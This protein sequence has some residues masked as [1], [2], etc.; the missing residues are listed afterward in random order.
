[1]KEGKRPP[2]IS[3]ALLATLLLAL[4]VRALGFEWVFIDADTVVFPPSDAQYHVRRSLYAWVNFPRVL[5][6]DP[7]INYPDGAAISWPPLFDF[8]VG[9]AAKLLARDTYS[10]QVVAAW[11]PPILGSIL[12]FPVYLLGRELGSRG[13]GVGAAAL[14]AM[15]PMS[16][17]YSRIGQLDHHCAV[18]FVG[19][20]LL[21]IVVRLVAETGSMLRLGIAF[22]LAGSAMLL[23]WH[24]S[25]LYLGMAEAILCVGAAL[26]GR[27][28]LYAVQAGSA[29][30]ILFVIGPVVWLFPEPLAGPYSAI[31]LSRLHVLAVMTV[32]LVSGS[33]WWGVRPGQGLR[34]RSPTARLAWTAFLLAAIAA[35]LLLLPGP[36]EGLEPAF[37][38]LTMTD[39]VG[40]RTGEQLP[41]F[42]LFGR[43]PGRPAWEIWGLFAYVIALAPVALVLSAPRDRRPAAWVLAAWCTVFGGLALVQ[44]RYGNDLGP[45]VAVAFAV[46]LAELSR[47]AASKFQSRACLAPVL[48]CG[49][50]LVMLAPPVWGQYR[51]LALN[52]VKALR[53]GN[54]GYDRASVTVAGTLTRFMQLVRRASP[55]TSGYFNVRDLPE[56]GIVAHANLGHSL[57]NIARRPTPT[58]P[59]WAFIGRENWNRSF[60]LLEAD[61]EARA[62]ELALQLRARYVVTMSSSDPRTLEGWLHHRDGLAARGWAASQHFRLIAEA[63]AGGVPLVGLFQRKGRRRSALARNTIPY[64]LFEIVNAAVLEVSAE[65]GAEVQL[66]LSLESPTGRSLRYQARA[67]AGPEGLARLRV[68]Y[69]TDGAADEPADGIRVFASDLYQVRVADCTVA[70]PVTDG[71]VRTGAVIVVPANADACRNSPPDA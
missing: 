49:I 54:D 57:Q 68:P 70:V 67:V 45:A 61:S 41:L 16:V 14:I 6:W 39:G 46:T 31:A 11:I 60:Q 38:F 64:K 48:A 13:V 25:L 17:T 69:S 50:G 62:L 9:A 27:R 1:M 7:Y 43:R 34:A 37:R 56:Y 12:V 65:P 66:R 5:L 23:T 59:F 42:S 18:V 22:S 33:L 51:R 35:I 36:R 10:F 19:A 44:R 30:A 8:A 20:W 28:S 58:D 2:W 55:E 40:R 32:A 29:L 26:T 24:G 71:Q 3:F 15:F 21:L 53:G 47:R 52:S 4:A 63:D